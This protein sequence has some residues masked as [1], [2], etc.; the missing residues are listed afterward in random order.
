[1]GFLL[2][3]E[4]SFSSTDK[5]YVAL[6]SDATV[7]YSI[8]CGIDNNGEPHTNMFL[9]QLNNTKTF[10]GGAANSNQ[11]YYLVVKMQADA[12]AWTNVTL[13][14]NPTNRLA[15]QAENTVTAS[16]S[17]ANDLSKLLV[18]QA[19][20]TTAARLFYVDQITIG[21]TWGDVVYSN[22]SPALVVLYSFSVADE[23]GVVVVRWRTASENDT[24]GF[25]VERWD[26][27]QFVRLNSEPIF[28]PQNG[29]GNSYSFTDV[30]AVPGNTYTYRLIEIE[31]D[32]E[33][34][35]YGPFDRT[36]S[37][38]QIQPPI[39]AGSDG[40]VIRWLSREDEAY[41]ILRATDLLTGF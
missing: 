17:F 13:F 15:E 10:G 2:R 14:I 3:C 16:A 34:E 8:S 19:G 37:A 24:V 5:R 31:G 39:T 12:S 23:G 9:C 33:M 30:T 38:L 41:N 20:M 21:K 29:M 4:G 32:C 1:M 28:S 6:D 7:T 25:Y 22:E 27:E 35:M 36:A 18:Q 11:T 26:G 40:M